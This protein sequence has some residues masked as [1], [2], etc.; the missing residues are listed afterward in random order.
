MLN[1]NLQ[2]T[3]RHIPDDSNFIVITVRTIN[4]AYCYSFGNLLCP[5]VRK[6]AVDSPKRSDIP[7]HSPQDNGLLQIL[8]CVAVT[9]HKTV[10]LCKTKGTRL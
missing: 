3:R 10:V 9:E 7:D 2:T 8:V 1:T 5:V 4:L 6:E